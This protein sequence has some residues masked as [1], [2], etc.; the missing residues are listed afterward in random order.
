M[1]NTAIAAYKMGRVIRV[2][3]SDLDSFLEG[4]RVQPG[5]LSHLYPERIEPE[6]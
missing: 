1:I 4:T 2:K 5:S 6:G 3:E